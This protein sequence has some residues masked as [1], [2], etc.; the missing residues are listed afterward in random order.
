MACPGRLSPQ[1]IW[2]IAEQLS[3]SNWLFLYYLGSNLDPV[4]FRNLFGDIAAEIRLRTS[5]TNSAADIEEENSENEMI[6][7]VEAGHMLKV[8][9]KE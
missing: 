3:F 4:V 6:D 5:S 9:K 1:D 8:H 7:L 2:T